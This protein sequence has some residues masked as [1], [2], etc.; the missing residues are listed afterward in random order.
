MTLL[1]EDVDGGVQE[2][3]MTDDD[4]ITLARQM[5]ESLPKFGAWANGFREFETPYGKVGFRQLAILWFLRFELPSGEH[6]TPTRIAESS[7]VQP[8]VITRALTRLEAAGFI[9]RKVDPTDHRR[10]FVTITDRGLEIS[11]YVEDWYTREM[12]E[13]IGDLSNEQLGELERSVALLDGLAN[14]LRRRQT[15]HRD[16]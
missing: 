13:C 10:F 15:G 5:V 14:T 4:R 2:T 9:E 1:P 16:E 3:V 11:R 12:L 6:V 8:S 7:S